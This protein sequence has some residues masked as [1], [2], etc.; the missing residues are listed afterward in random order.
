MALISISEAKELGLRG[1]D[2]YN[3]SQIYLLSEVHRISI[4]LELQREAFKLLR[5]S[6]FI[7][8]FLQLETEA[9]QMKD[10]L[11]KY[12]FPKALDYRSQ[13]LTDYYHEHIRLDWH[14]IALAIE[15]HLKAILIELEIVVNEIA[16]LPNNSEANELHVKQR[17]QPVYISELSNFDF[18]YE[19]DLGRNINPILSN[20]S[21][22]FFN[23]LGEKLLRRYIRHIRPNY[24][25]I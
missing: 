2:M 15:I 14:I 11:E 13:P 5:R 6:I 20:K 22:N 3:A 23:N 16:R 1:H 4:S 8:Q 17:R 9:C 10:N 12:G 7:T 24:S 18:M 21:I 19:T 25:N